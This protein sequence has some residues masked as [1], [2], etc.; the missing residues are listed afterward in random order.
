MSG[1][2]DKICCDFST[3]ILRFNSYV[4]DKFNRKIINYEKFKKA[5]QRKS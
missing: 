3:D 5:F 4:C 1:K 2:C